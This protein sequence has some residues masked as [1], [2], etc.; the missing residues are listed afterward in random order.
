MHQQ[1]PLE[2]NTSTIICIVKDLT[3]INSHSKNEAFN[4]PST[5]QV[6]D[7]IKEVATRFNYEPHT[8][9]LNWKCQNDLVST[10]T[11]QNPSKTH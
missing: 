6:S 8:F 1:L 11:P 3:D 9:T 7:L 5:Y 2:I 10:K 4:L